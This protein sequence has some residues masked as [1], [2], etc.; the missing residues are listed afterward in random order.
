[1]SVFAGTVT[2]TTGISFVPNEAVLSAEMRFLNVP[3][4]VFPRS[5][6]SISPMRSCTERILVSWLMFHS[7]ALRSISTDGTVP[8]V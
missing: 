7:I 5:D 2:G 8:V 4:S 3:S 6:I 1:M